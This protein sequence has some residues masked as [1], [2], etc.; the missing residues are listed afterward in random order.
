LG[1]L[2]A[3]SEPR[4]A[5]RRRESAADAKNA[6]GASFAL[7]RAMKHPSLSF[8][9]K[10]IPVIL[11][12]TAALAA[13]CGQASPEDS[14]GSVSSADTV[15]LGTSFYDGG[16]QCIVGGAQMHCCPTGS[17][18][19][20]ARVDQNVFKC[21]NLIDRSGAITLDTGTQRNG[22]HSCPFGQV[23]VGLRADQ[24][25]LACQR[26]PNNPVVSETV[27]TGTQDGFP[28]HICSEATGHAAMT[29]IRIDQNRFNCG[30]DNNCLFGA[31]TNN[32]QCTRNEGVCASNGCCTL[33]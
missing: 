21:A 14:T 22:M 17:A 25:L 31:C 23:M 28:M 8:G 33:G 9:W 6:S 4:V 24:N 5:P 15:N 3:Q 30:Q 27:D 19:I 7:E 29:G 16:T 12:I 10:P 26:I 13:G 20:G 18:M 32:S 11:I 2:V 1:K